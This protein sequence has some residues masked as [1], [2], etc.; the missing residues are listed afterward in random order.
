MKNFDVQSIR[1]DIPL[2]AAFEYISQPDNLPKWTNAFASANS[3]EAVLRTPQGEVP[4]SLKVDA[5]L[6]AG[7]VDWYMGFPD[8][9][10]ATAFSRLISLSAQQCVFSFVL[11]PPPVPLEVLE[12]ALSTQSEILKEELKSLKQ[13]LELNA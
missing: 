1:F 10:E 11:T 9:S 8:G 5:S 2:S 12:G 13:I 7:T 6:H 4:I 3:S